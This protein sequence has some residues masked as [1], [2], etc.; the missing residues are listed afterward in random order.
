MK[1][2]TKPERLLEALSDRDWH[3]TQELVR[4][5]GHTFGHT[6]FLLVGD[7]YHYTI[8]KRRHPSRKHQWQYRL[9]A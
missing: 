6:K 5:V 4:E 7:R 8:D 3:D 9:V 1:R 2:R